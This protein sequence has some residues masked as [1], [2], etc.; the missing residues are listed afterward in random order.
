MIKRTLKIII[1]TVVNR[2]AVDIFLG[3]LELAPIK[4]ILYDL[5][6]SIV[7]SI[8]IVII[9][10]YYEPTIKEIIDFILQNLGIVI[11]VLSILAGFNIT[12]VAV[13]ATSQS[14]LTKSLKEKFINNSLHTY[15]EQIISYFSW[16]I[17]VQLAILLL[18]IAAFFILKF[19]FPLENK[20]IFNL[21]SIKMT[22]LNLIKL[23][24]F[25]GLFMIFYSITLTVRNVSILYY[26]LI[27]NAKH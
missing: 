16:A 6:F 12:S 22:S 25:A 3:Y 19:A 8:I 2:E 17:L 5:I 7:F 9:I 27:S 1:N 26:Y 18:S 11:T 24:T 15:L 23:I 14:I 20:I 13:I 4:E 10:F 21:L